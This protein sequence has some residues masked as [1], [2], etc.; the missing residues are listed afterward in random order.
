MHT[1]DININA[2]KKRT[3]FSLFKHSKDQISEDDIEILESLEIVRDDLNHAH[4]CLNHIT[5]PLLID[6]YIFQIQ[7]LNKMYQFYLKQCRERD[8][9]ADVGDI[10]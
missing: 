1:V 2:P 7:S 10:Y 6:S 5:D 8:L 9:V 3:R 4:E